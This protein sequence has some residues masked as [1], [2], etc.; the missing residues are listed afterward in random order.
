[1]L[2]LLINSLCLLTDSYGLGFLLFLVYSKHFLLLLFSP[3][4]RQ[5][6]PQWLAASVRALHEF[7][8]RLHPS[9]PLILP[10]GFTTPGSALIHASGRDA[11]P[12]DI[13]SCR[14]RFVSA[15]LPARGLPARQPTA[16]QPFGL[17]GRGRGAAASC[18]V[19]ARSGAMEEPG[20]GRVPLRGPC[21]RLHASQESRGTRPGA[22]R[23]GWV[24]GTAVTSVGPV[25]RRQAGRG[26]TARVR[27]G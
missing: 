23:R 22:R 9:R 13:T 26:N 21:P 6:F 18:R 24:W 20:H 11:V 7:T 3:A 15:A 5:C 19:G 17:R 2:L 12:R 16:S 14:G 4:S 27:A 10:Q 25:L 1:M 8:A